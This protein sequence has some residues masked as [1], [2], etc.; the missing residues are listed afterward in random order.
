MFL[1]SATCWCVNLSI[2]PYLTPSSTTHLLRI[3]VILHY[4]F[5]FPFL[6]S[7]AHFLRTSPISRP[8]SS[9]ESWYCLSSHSLLPMTWSSH[10]PNVTRSLSSWYAYPGS[11]SNTLI[12][13]DGVAVAG[14][15]RG[16][17]TGNPTPGNPT[18][19][20]TPSE[21]LRCCSLPLWA[22]PL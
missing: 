10:Y 13:R 21:R 3:P 9:L 11:R 14:V 7:N 6:V 2:P 22:A 20:S 12:I 17:L 4:S 1:H 18:G 19:A 15:E 5:L 8:K 16:A